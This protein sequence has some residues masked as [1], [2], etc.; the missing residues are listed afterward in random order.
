MAKKKTN[1]EMDNITELEDAVTVVEK[2]I[3]E[4]AEKPQVVLSKEKICE[5][6]WITDKDILDPTVDLRKFNIKPEEVDVLSDWAMKNVKAVLKDVTFDVFTCSPE[7]KAII[8]KYGLT[9][10]HVANNKL[11]ELSEEEKDLIVAYYTERSVEKF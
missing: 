5:F 7:V 10:D 1:P 2:K 3:D 9:P 4:K 6:Y 8:E 11:D